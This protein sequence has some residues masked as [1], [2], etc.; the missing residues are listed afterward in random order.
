LTSIISCHS[1]DDSSRKG[2][3]VMTPALFTS[4]SASIAPSAFATADPSRRS[5]T[6]GVHVPPPVAISAA[7]AS[8]ARRLRAI[9]TTW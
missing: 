9:V 8:S 2:F 5:T 1:S 3:F 4:T 6:S 7:S